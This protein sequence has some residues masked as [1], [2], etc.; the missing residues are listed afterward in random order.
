VAKPLEPAA[1]EVSFLATSTILADNI[2]KKWVL[3]TLKY[4]HGCDNFYF[5]TKVA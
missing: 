4:F 1:A 3:T 2:V 5:T